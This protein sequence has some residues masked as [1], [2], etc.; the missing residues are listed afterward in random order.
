MKNLMEGKKIISF[1]DIFPDDLLQLKIN[2]DKLKIE[3]PELLKKFNEK[4]NNSKEVNIFEEIL[5]V[6]PQ[7]I[8]L[9]VVKYS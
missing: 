4:S 6:F 7:I 2:K 1:E 3:F 8:K 5:F 9:E